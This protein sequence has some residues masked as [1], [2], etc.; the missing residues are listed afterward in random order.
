MPPKKQNGGLID[1]G[2]ATVSIIKASE[3][4]MFSDPSTTYYS[5]NYMNTQNGGYVPSFA[6]KRTP[7]AAKKKKTRKTKKDTKDTKDN[8]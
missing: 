5:K 6:S 1:P 8:K 7:V 3:V 4:K 2:M